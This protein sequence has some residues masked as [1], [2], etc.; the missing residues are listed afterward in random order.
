MATLRKV[1]VEN[2]GG[3]DALEKHE[4][5]R[6]EWLEHTKIWQ[7]KETVF[8]KLVDME[9]Y[10]EENPPGISG[11]GRISNSRWRSSAL[12]GIDAIAAN[13]RCK[14]YA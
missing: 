6:P 11:C 3:E 14:R 7:L 8:K 9:E 10:V 4:G 5:G 12:Q 2:K 1:E 13:A